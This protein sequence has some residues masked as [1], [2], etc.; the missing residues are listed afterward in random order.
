MFYHRHYDPI[1]VYLPRGCMN[2]RNVSV[3]PCSSLY[4]KYFQHALYTILEISARNL[5]TRNITEYVWKVTTHLLLSKGVIITEG[6][7]AR[8]DL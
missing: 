7:E 4:S 3:R 2:R 6:D 5:E 1:V 8:N